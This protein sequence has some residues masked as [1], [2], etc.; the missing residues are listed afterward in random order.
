MSRLVR[1]VKIVLGLLLVGVVGLGIAAIVL[2]EPRPQ[3]ESGPEAD[4]LAR[5]VMAAA[6]V[7]AWGGVRAIKWTFGGR[8]DH[9]WDR[10]RGLVRVRQE[11]TEAL[12]DLSSER[13]HVVR[14]GQ[15]LTGAS[16]EEAQKKAYEAWVN[17]SFWLN[18]IPKF[19]DEGVTRSVVDLDGA[20]A[21]MISFSEGGVTPGDAYV[22]R[23]GE[24][25][26]PTAWRMWVGIIPTGGLV[27][28]WEDWIT[29]PGGAKVSTR[30]EGLAKLEL[31]DVQTAS[32]AAGL[33]GGADPF[34]PL[35]EAAA[36]PASQPAVPASRPA[37]V[38]E[39]ETPSAAPASAPAPDKEAPAE[40][41]AAPAPAA[42][43]E[44]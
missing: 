41:K 5:R 14:A 26:L 10:S 16:A 11:D 27:A 38:P 3:G 23:I 24:D 1:I 20:K 29:L 39:A 30:H 19:F 25:G 40:P 9:L 21:L 44:L 15:A 28:T 7:E 18:P 34:A 36:A 32:T 13:A 8:R 35:L 4:A 43:E 6:N 42:P 12:L 33:A 37:P 17:D 2:D 31:T 22:F